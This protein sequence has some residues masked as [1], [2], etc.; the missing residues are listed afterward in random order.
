MDINQCIIFCNT[1][2]RVEE[3]AESMTA[4]EHVVNTMHGEMD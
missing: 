1:K 2:R 4:N 3:L